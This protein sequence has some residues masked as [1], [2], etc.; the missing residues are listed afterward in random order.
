M[1][2][3]KPPRD[4]ELYGTANQFAAIE[5]EQFLS[6]GVHQLDASLDIDN[7]HGVRGRFQQSSELLILGF[8]VADVANSSRYQKPFFRL[9]RTQADLNRKF[10]AI[11]SQGIQL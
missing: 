2:L 10:L 4:Q 7:H 1:P 6:L 9:Q 8:S 5:T 11:A 3:A